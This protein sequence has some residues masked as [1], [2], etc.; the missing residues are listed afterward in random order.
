MQ[1]FDTTDPRHSSNLGI[2]IESSSTA[3]SAPQAI[4]T[5]REVED[6]RL[7]YATIDQVAERQRNLGSGAFYGDATDDGRSKT[8]LGRLCVT[9]PW[10]T[11]L[12]SSILNPQPFDNYCIMHGYVNES[13]E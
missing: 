4:V 3:T 12:F 11:G 2:S 9:R 5:T 7:A 6:Q 8:F 1:S 13:V 10:A